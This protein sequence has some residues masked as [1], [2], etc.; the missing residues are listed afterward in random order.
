MGV[1]SPALPHPPAPRPQMHPLAP[2]GVGK[3]LLGKKVEGDGR[4]PLGRIPAAAPSNAARSS[5]RRPSCTRA[6][7]DPPRQFAGEL[8]LLDAALRPEPD[9][10]AGARGEGAAGMRGDGD[11][12]AGLEA[13]LQERER[14][15]AG[16]ERE[17]LVAGQEK[18]GGETERE[19]R[20]WERERETGRPREGEITDKVSF[21]ILPLSFFNNYILVPKTSISSHSNP[22]NFYFLTF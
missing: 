18:E 7:L 13:A 15:A 5:P 10:I 19:K 12:G 14:P 21:F 4:R 17:A 20:E 9:P 8:V 6:A 11:A 1:S 16:R 3:E 22:Y 2:R